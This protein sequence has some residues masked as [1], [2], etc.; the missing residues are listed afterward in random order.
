MKAEEKLEHGL[1]MIFVYG[2]PSTSCLKML[3]NLKASLEV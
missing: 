2:Q 1:V 3:N